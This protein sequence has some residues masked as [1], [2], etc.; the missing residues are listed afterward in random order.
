MKQKN[1]Q[2]ISRTAF[3]LFGGNLNNRS[4]VGCSYFNLNS[5]AGAA[6][7]NI[8]ASQSYQLK[9]QCSAFSSP[10]GENELGASTLQ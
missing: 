9:K 7:R 4:Q 2:G 10:L 1:T 5:D 3:A 8:G 6:N